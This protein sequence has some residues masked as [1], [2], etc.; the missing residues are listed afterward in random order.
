MYALEGLDLGK[1]H[2]R[3]PANSVS[4]IQKKISVAQQKIS[5]LQT[6]LSHTTKV[7]TQHK[8]QAEIL[9]WQ[10]R[11][12][13][14]QLQLAQLQIGIQPPATPTTPTPLDVSLPAPT[15]LIPWDLAPQTP[16]STTTTTSTTVPIETT[17]P[18]SFFSNPWILGGG[19]ILLFLMMRK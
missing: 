17:Q 5:D 9:E 16:T 2:P 8:I 14:Y 7:K 13:D 18:V 15:I 11:L 1:R 10:K 3:P 12:T 6:K 4:V 19:A